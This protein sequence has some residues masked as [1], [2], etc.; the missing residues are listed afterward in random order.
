MSADQAVL[1]PALLRH[2]QERVPV[3]RHAVS[4][5]QLPGPSVAPLRLH[6]AEGGLLQLVPRHEHP[7]QAHH[8]HHRPLKRIRTAG[9]SAPSSHTEPP[10]L[11]WLNTI[12]IKPCSFIV[13]CCFLNMISLIRKPAVVYVRVADLY[14]SVSIYESRNAEKW[15]PPSCCL[16]YKLL[17]LWL[18]FLYYVK[19]EI[20][21]GRP[22]TSF[23]HL[24]WRR[25]ASKMHFFDDVWQIWSRRDKRVIFWFLLHSCVAAALESQ[26]PARVCRS[27]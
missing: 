18:V 9:T 22:I 2:V 15:F 3:D 16:W 14:G 13:M 25:R 12:A 21:N 26:P 10:A 17:E 27:C 1:L 23:L 24:G 4:T 7:R 20:I 8:Q 19:A 5:L 6:P 11:T